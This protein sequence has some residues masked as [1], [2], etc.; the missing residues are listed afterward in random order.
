MGLSWV[1]DKGY[2]GVSYNERRDHYGIPGHN[3]EFDYCSGHLFDTTNLLNITKV[4]SYLLAYPHLMG[5]EDMIGNLH[6]HCGTE[7]SGEKHSH[8]NVYGHKHDISA[9]GPVIDMHSKRYDLRGEWRQP[10]WGIDRIKVALAY[11]DYYHDEKHDGKA[12]LNGTESEAYKNA[13]LHTAALMS[14]KPEAFFYNKGFNSRLEIYHQ[15][16]EHFNGLV[17]VQYQ[18]KKSK[19]T[20]LA[21]IVTNDI[22]NL[23]GERNEHDQH[24]LVENTEKQLSFFALEQINWRNF[25][26]ETGMR[27]ERQEIPI[28]YDK[29]KY[30]LSDEKDGP[31]LSP[32]R[33]NA[34]SY[35]GTLMWD[36]HPDYRL[37]LSASHNERMPSPMELYYHGKH[38]ATNSFEYGNK[39]LKKERSN[40]LELGLMH[41]SEK[42]DFKFSVYYQGFKN[43]IHNENIYRN[44]NLYM[45][46]YNQ[47]RS[48]NSLWSCL[49]C[50][51]ISFFSV[52]ISSIASS[53]AFSKVDFC[54]VIDYSYLLYIKDKKM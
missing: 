43:Y 12:H 21:S 22:N 7:L 36:F 40:N 35:S 51:A 47:S 50:A 37:S 8:S 32:Y 10:M 5:D 38:L 33:D 44:A 45:R 26:L 16:T 53:S 2:L 19:A 3:H 18:T 20:R 29:S 1:G 13:L 24:P 34:V 28:K 48:F 14:G 52:S 30:N 9:P 27:W 6:F 46:R 42:W 23:S 49:I 31:D 54:F 25:I 41:A 11:A 17:G 4:K 39:D 15:P